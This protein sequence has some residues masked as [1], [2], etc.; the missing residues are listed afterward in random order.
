MHTWAGGGMGVSPSIWDK[1]H[2]VGRSKALPPPRECRPGSNLRCAL[3]VVKGGLQDPM[4]P[5]GSPPGRAQVL[6]A[7]GV[8]ELTQSVPLDMEPPHSR[9]R[10]Q[11]AAL[12]SKMG[13]I[14]QLLRRAEPGGGSADT[15]AP[16]TPG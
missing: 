9:P 16:S 6:H 4:A 3:K 15:L 2:K 13:G 14:P 11:V 5:T 7:E 1:E 12:P 10:H 8:S